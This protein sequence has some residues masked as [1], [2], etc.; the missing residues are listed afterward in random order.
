MESTVYDRMLVMLEGVHPP[1]AGSQADVDAVKS[2]RSNFRVF[3]LLT[4]SQV[5]SLL[6]AVGDDGAADLLL[7]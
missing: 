6:V 1:P 4:N 2:G 5:C 7:Y 3:L